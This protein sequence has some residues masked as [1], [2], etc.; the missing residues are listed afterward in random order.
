MKYKNQLSELHESI[1]REI[2]DMRNQEMAESIA[3]KR[4]NAKEAEER[5]QIATKAIEAMGLK[6]AS[7]DALDREITAQREKD[8]LTIQTQME[9]L[10]Q[11]PKIITDSLEIEATFLPQDA[12]ILKPA[13][14]GTF[15]DDDAQDELTSSTTSITTQTLLTGGGCKNYY[16]WADRKSVV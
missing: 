9:A 3:T 2:V 16:N 6:V 10:S 5:Y 13:W 1:T 12:Y 15:S 7:L 11:E 8:L 14:V 4:K